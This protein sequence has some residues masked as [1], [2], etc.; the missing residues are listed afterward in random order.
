[1]KVLIQA[2]C[3]ATFKCAQLLRFPLNVI[4]VGQALVNSNNFDTKSKTLAKPKYGRSYSDQD[5]K[6]LVP[7]YGSDY[8]RYHGIVEGFV[9]II[10]TSLT[11]ALDQLNVLEKQT[12]TSAD[13]SSNSK[14]LLHIVRL[15]YS[16]KDYKQLAEQIASLSKKRALLKQV[17]IFLKPGRHQDDPGVYYFCW[18]NIR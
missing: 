2:S 7:N 13:L 17:V 18:G 15:C 4:S 9:Q 16:A 5:G 1:M 11:E 6:G 14:V 12:R 10:K 8:Y 3:I